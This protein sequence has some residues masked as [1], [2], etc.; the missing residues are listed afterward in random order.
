MLLAVSHDN[1]QFIRLPLDGVFL[2]VHGA[3]V[4]HSGSCRVALER[5]GY[6]RQN[7]RGQLPSQWKK[8]PRTLMPGWGATVRHISDYPLQVTKP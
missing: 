8:C 3:E 4:E 1:A 7:L 5:L 2:S 6:P